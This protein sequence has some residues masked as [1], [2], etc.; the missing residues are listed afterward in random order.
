[1]WSSKNGFEYLQMLLIYIT[2]KN[3]VFKLKSYIQLMLSHESYA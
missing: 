3:K 1:M 2:F